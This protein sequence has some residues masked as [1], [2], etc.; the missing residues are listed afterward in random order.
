MLTKEREL[1]T[2]IVPPMSRPTLQQAIYV[3]Q[4]APDLLVEKF[5][6]IILPSSVGGDEGKLLGRLREKYRVIGYWLRY[7]LQ[8]ENHLKFELLE[9]RKQ[10]C[11]PFAEIL[12]NYFFLAKHLAAHQKSSHV[13]AQMT[14]EYL[15][16][17]VA[18]QHCCEDLNNSGFLNLPKPEGKEMTYALARDHYDSLL[19]TGLPFTRSEGKEVAIQPKEFLEG[20]A[21]WLANN[22]TEFRS[23]YFYEY[24]RSQK[25]CYRQ[26]K[27]N[28]QLKASYLNGNELKH[29]SRG[30]GGKRRVL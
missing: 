25:R 14:P 26:I 29:M 16:L 30:R 5:H 12:Q 3:I 21:A 4:N 27:A 2:E 20:L 6:G 1:F 7:F 19:S 24:T 28:P 13:M 8:H 9:S 17:M 15:L 10:L 23:G 11:K 22:D 18:L